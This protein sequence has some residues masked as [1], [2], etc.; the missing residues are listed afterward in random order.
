MFS[1]SVKRFYADHLVPNMQRFDTNGM[2][3]R[4]FWKKA[5]EIG[6]M[7]GSVPEEYEGSGGSYGF[8]SIALY[9]QGKIGD[10][11]WGYGIQSIVIHYL[12][13]YGSYEQKAYWLPQLVSGESIGALAMTEPGCGSDVQ[14]IQTTAEKKGNHYLVNG[15]KTFITNGGSSDV[16][17]L[18]TK[19][20]ASKGAKGVSLILVDTRDLE[21]FR[22]GPRMNKLGQRGNDTA[23]LFFDN[24]MVPRTNLLGEEEGQ[25]FYQLMK[26][27]PWERLLI[28]ITALGIIDFALEQTISYV[29][30][31]KA[32]GK[33]L[34]DL[35]NT[36]FKLAEAKTKAELLRTFVNDCIQRIENNELDAATA[37]M[38]KYWGSEV[39]NQII[40]ECLQL[41]GGYG[42]MLD[43]PIARLYADSRVQMIY[44]GSNEIMKELIARSMDN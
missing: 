6:I 40:S 22:R 24:V 44:G 38:V 36:R 39:Q 18:A 28:G 37:S 35:Q 19:T 12:I 25:G 21:G 9:E 26:Q 31:R 7:G 17:V 20:E 11:S 15:S 34:M 10:G 1:D 42:Y 43:Y 3:D 23:E 5:G 4:D 33:R 14:S 30:E 32:F 16:I 29:Q 13:K 2:V 27:L 8:D 41:H